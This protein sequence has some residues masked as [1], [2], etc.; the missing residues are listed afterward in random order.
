MGYSHRPAK[1]RLATSCVSLGAASRRAITTVD[2]PLPLCRIAS[3]GLGFKAQSV[4]TS[5]FELRLSSRIASST[6]QCSS[7]PVWPHAAKRHILL[8]SGASEPDRPHRVSGPS[9]LSKSP[10][11]H[12]RPSPRAV[13]TAARRLSRR[14]S[15][16]PNPSLQRTRARSP[17]ES[18]TQNP[19]GRA[20][21]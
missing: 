7:H 4:S 9:W 19:R 20:L 16:R 14:C 17:L 8:S 1:A 15:G 13:A 11:V 21:K 10:R 6:V 5:R 18:G 2:P 3:W 12:G